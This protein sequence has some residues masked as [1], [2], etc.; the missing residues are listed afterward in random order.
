MPESEKAHEMDIYDRKENRRG[1]IKIINNPGLV[2]KSQRIIPKQ[3][4]MLP[5]Y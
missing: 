5:G 1:K 2:G 3:V 4:I